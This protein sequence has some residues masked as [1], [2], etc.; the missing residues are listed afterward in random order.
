MKIEWEW[1]E[2]DRRSV[3]LGEGTSLRST[4]IDEESNVSLMLNVSFALQMAH[5]DGMTPAML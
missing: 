5:Q 4:E 2:K 1:C 3:R